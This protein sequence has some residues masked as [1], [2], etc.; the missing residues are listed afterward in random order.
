VNAQPAEVTKPGAKPQA[1][2]PSTAG[3]LAK[4]VAALLVRAPG[5]ASGK[6]AP[7]AK[8]AKT[9]G[10]TE[11][12]ASATNDEAPATAPAAVATLPLPFIMPVAISVAPQ[13]IEMK[14][15]AAAA[16]RPTPG[17]PAPAVSAAASHKAQVPTDAVTTATTVPAAAAAETAAQIVVNFALP[18]APA[19]QAPATLKPPVPPKPT[20]QQLAAHQTDAV[21]LTATK[22]QGEAAAKP[23]T[24]LVPATP[25]A[26]QTA[27]QPSRTAA[28]DAAAPA[29]ADAV[30]DAPATTPSAEAQTLP[31]VANAPSFAQ[32]LAPVA[33]APTT[34]AAQLS[35]HDF[36]AL[37]DR[38]VE[39]R[40]AASPRGVLAA[41]SHSEFGQVSL[42]FDQDANGL[43]VSMSSADPD[44]ARAVQANAASAGSQTATD[45][46]SAPR[47]DTQGHPQQQAAGSSLGQSQSQAQSQAYSRDD[48]SPQTGPE[49][50]T[51]TRQNPETD[52]SDA[53][54]DIFA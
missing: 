7:A 24:A 20:V 41:I 8:P 28:H 27:E 44:F 6:T 50:R 22:M 40:E 9:D 15:V 29:K 32:T 35:S 25:L 53:S 14:A 12:T 17:Q 39:A 36:T 3:N 4:T 37:V 34:G 5:S 42:R 47:Q 11:E 45:N 31:V 21:P 19:E 1:N 18:Q 49:L 33:A 16:A 46:G 30:T 51:A 54:G 43:S 2:L 26:T 48:R 10:K 52:H 38:L 13:P 23:Q